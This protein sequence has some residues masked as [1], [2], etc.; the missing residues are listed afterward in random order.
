ME[1]TSLNSY[2][3]SI[4]ISSDGFSL[5]VYNEANFLLSSK[6]INAT[7][8]K[9][10]FD[11]VLNLFSLETQLN[12]TTLRLIYETDTYT[13]IPA[14]F[15]VE[16]EAIDFLSLG[17]ELRKEDKI[18]F[19][20]LE[21]WDIVNA[22]AIPVTVHDA[23]VRL[24]PHTAIEHH[25]SYLL[26]YKIQSPIESCLYCQV[27][28]KTL[29]LIVLKGGKIQFVNSFSYQTPED[30]I[31]FTLSIYKKHSL[32]TNNSPIYFLNA[33]TRPELKEMLEKYVTVISEQ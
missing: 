18:L 9:L 2:H 21:M 27:E 8:T 7:L 19:N 28:T 31:Y 23:L 6:K 26:T 32:D 30:F 15:F 3:L 10:T 29:D 1:I 20:K 17:H 22:F 16:E 5:S 25:L 12:Y 11:E 24:F 4:R 33:A 14:D 13:I